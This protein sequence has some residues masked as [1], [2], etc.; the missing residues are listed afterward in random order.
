MGLFI[1][2]VGIAYT[3]V[4]KLEPNVDPNQFKIV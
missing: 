4:A 2:G 1:E 3:A